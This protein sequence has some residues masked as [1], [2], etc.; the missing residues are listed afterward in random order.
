[1]Y[2]PVKFIDC[3]LVG[4][5]Q[6]DVVDIGVNGCIDM[7]TA[8]LPLPRVVYPGLPYGSVGHRQ[9]KDYRP[10]VHVLTVIPYDKNQRYIYFGLARSF[11]SDIWYWTRMIRI[12]DLAWISRKN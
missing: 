11:N 9:D 7:P 5:K 10:A 4:I 2:M 3:T 1:M 8:K 6:I 12:G